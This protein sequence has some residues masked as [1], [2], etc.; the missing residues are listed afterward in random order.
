MIIQ[1]ACSSKP[2]SKVDTYFHNDSTLIELDVTKTYPRKEYC[3][4]DIAAVEYVSTH[5]KTYKYA[6]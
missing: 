4:Q 3:L 2:T 5:R 1:A 6:W